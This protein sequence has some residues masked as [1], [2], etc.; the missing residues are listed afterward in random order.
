MKTDTKQIQQ[1]NSFVGTEEYIAPEVITGV[2]HTSSV[3]WWTFG[4]LIFEMLFGCTPFKGGSQKDTFNHI[5]TK[6]IDFPSKGGVA[7]NKSCKDLIKKLLH[8]D[9]KKRLGHKNGAADIKAHPFFKGVNWALIRNEQP[10]IRIDIKD[11]YD[12]SYF[13]NLNDSDDERDDDDDSGLPQEDNPNAS[14]FKDF[15][16]APTAFHKNLY[17]VD[18]DH[19]QSLPKHLSLLKS[20]LPLNI[21]QEVEKSPSQD[22]HMETPVHRT[23]SAL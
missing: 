14:V 21:K 12:T 15:R 9:Q 6:K 3:D 2:G 13:R 22:G 18:T 16:Y 17:G 7:I 4:I 20:E 19:P 8:I 11:K 1:F 5:L 10:P 23:Q